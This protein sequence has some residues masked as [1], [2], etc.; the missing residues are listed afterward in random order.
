MSVKF[1]DFLQ[2]QLWDPE[3]RKEYEALQ[4]E[5]AIIQAIIDARQQSGMTQKELAEKTGIAQ[6]D[7][8]KLERGNAN[9]SIRTLQ[10]LAAGMGMTIKLGFQPVPEKMAAQ[11]KA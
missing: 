3:F 8:S 6:G 2:E 5:H 10:R 11:S 9:P 7:I 4:P 1:D